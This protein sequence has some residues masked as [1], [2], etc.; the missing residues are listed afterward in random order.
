M[1]KELMDLLLWLSSRKVNVK[2][3]VNVAVNGMIQHDTLLIIE[4]PPVIISE[5]N[6]ELSVL[7][8]DK[9]ILSASICNGGL[10]INC[11]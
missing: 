11:R 8:K 5:I 9:T 10:F 1:K 3:E 6:D 2:F 7:N 4:C